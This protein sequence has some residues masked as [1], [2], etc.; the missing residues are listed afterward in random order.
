MSCVHTQPHPRPFIF[1][2]TVYAP[3][4]TD[5]EDDFAFAIKTFAEHGVEVRVDATHE[6]DAIVLDH[7]MQKKLHKPSYS[8]PVYYVETVVLREDGEDK[9]F[10]GL[11]WKRMGQSFIAVSTNARTSTL[12]HEIGHA[13]G[14]G[15]FDAK[16][17]IMCAKRG[18]KPGF[19]PWQG[20]LMRRGNLLSPR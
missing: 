16:T 7:A 10:N 12:S 6:I 4:G 15:H 11:Q 2:V 9:E 20:K 19:T 14:L 13:L 18:D 5:Y 17:N 3:A 8:T 1:H